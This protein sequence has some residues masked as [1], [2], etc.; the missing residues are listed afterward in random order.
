MPPSAIT[1][2]Y[3]PGLEHVLGARRRDVGDRRRL[4][5]ADPEHAAGGA[6]GARADADEHAD[7]TGPHQVQA[8]RVGGAAPDDAGHRGAGDELLEVERLRGRGDV[9]GR[10]HRALDDEDVEAGLERGLVVL[11]DLLRGQRAGADGALGLDLL[12]PL[13][14]QLRLDGLRVDL[15]HQPRRLAGRCRRDPGELLVGVLV[16]GPDALE[17]EDAESTEAVDQRRGPRADDAVH[18]RGEERQL[19]AVGAEVPGDVDVVGVTRPPRGHDRDVVEPVGP[20]SLLSPSDLNFQ[21]VA[22]PWST[23]AKQRL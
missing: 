15:L 10:D 1:L 4:G 22:L 6:G 23:A 18:R 2:Q 8:G 9:L 5:D 17:V 11:A 20:T 3:S 12:D 14:D 13:R 16:A 19:E 21:L 7:R